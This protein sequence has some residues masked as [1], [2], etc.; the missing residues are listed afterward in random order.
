ML[1]NGLTALAEN[2]FAFQFDISPDGVVLPPNAGT[3]LFSF[4]NDPGD[5]THLLTSLGAFD[6]S[7]AFGEDTYI[8]ADIVT[9]L[10]E[11]LVI[12]SRIGSVRRLQFSNINPFGSGPFNGSLDLVNSANHTLS[13][14]PPGF[15][16][17]LSLYS[18]STQPMQF[19]SG[20]YQA[21]QIP[22]PTSFVLIATVIAGL[23]VFARRPSLATFVAKVNAPVQPA[24]SRPISR[25]VMKRSI[26]TVLEG[27][28]KRLIIVTNGP[29]N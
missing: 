23:V 25:T 6:I 13:F 17:G 18:E 29:V 11:V 27:H 28:V 14:E 20:D 21:S 15:G 1:A 9:P 10:S 8:E 3:G 4:A 5:G 7:F 12:L 24:Q 26:C 19:V 2:I 16:L 22:E